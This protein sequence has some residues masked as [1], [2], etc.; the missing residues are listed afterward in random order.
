MNACRLVRK[1]GPALLVA[2]MCIG[3]TVL[4]DDQVPTIK[5]EASVISKKVIAMSSSGVPTEEVSVARRVS[6]AD[7]DLKTYVGA[8]ALKRRVHKAAELACKQVDDLYPLERPEAPSCIRQA[9]AAANQQVE[10]A[11]ADAQRTAEK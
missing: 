3:T 7:L 9:L 11:I 5:I 10:A 8:A 1:L 6:Y 4:A 2:G